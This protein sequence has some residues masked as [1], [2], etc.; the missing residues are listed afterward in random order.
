MTNA[1]LKFL[2]MVPRALNEIAETL[3]GIKKAL[4]EIK[5]KN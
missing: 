3:E 5:N 2:E 4:E 1:E